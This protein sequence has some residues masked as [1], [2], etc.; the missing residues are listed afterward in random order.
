MDVIYSK[1]QVFKEYYNDERSFEEQINKDLEDNPN[2][3]ID[4][5]QVIH[6]HDN[7]YQCFVVYK[8]NDSVSWETKSNR[9][10]T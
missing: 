1:K 9:E 5:F 6:L 4:S 3:S 2:W 8:Y 7:F 10:Y